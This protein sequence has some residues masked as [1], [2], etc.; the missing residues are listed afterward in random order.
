M[1]H[2]VSEQVE[3]GGG[4]R[5]FAAVHEHP[6]RAA[7]EGDATEDED[8]A[9]VGG[10][11]VA[12][13]HLDPR[14]DLSRAEGLGDVVIAA[15]LE[16][17]DAVHLVVARRAEEHRGPVILGAHPTTDLRAV[18]AGEADIE[19]HGIRS[20]LT[21]GGKPPQAVGLDRHGIARSIQ[22]ETEHVGNGGL[23]LDD[24]DE[25]RSVGGRQC[26]RRSS[27]SVRQ[28]ARAACRARRPS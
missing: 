3:L 22:V 27:T 2:E 28:R 21:D 18:H 24:E 19:D 16:T 10:M 13:G 26:D 5:H 4:E 6:A 17:E 8:V 20:P 7:I 1:L 23:V 14:H 11:G 25:G 9:R 15:H 12:Q